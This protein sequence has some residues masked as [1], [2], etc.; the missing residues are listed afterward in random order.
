[1]TKFHGFAPVFDK[2]CRVLILGSFPSVKSRAADFYYGNKQNRFWRV[3]C[4]AFKQPQVATVEDKKRLCLSNGIALWDIVDSCDIRGSM[5]ADITNYTLVDLST[6]LD[7]AP[8]Q[9]ILCNGA[10]SYRLTKSVYSGQIPVYKLSSTSP[11]NP[12]FNREEW[13]QQLTG[14]PVQG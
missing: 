7:N 10:T 9:K 6:V 3:L 1:M 4:E 12:R 13:L 2:N 5:D 11:A 14:F 8:I